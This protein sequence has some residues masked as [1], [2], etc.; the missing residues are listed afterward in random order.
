[1]VANDKD[2][3]GDTAAT[4]VIVIVVLRFDLL[5]ESRFVSLHPQPG[6]S[7]E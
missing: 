6:I 5:R 4:I 3:D 7:H 1:M 2:D